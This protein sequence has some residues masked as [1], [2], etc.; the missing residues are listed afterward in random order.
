MNDIRFIPLVLNSNQMGTQSLPQMDL[1]LS[2]NKEVVANL[3]NSTHGNGEAERFGSSALARIC[4]CLTTLVN[5]KI[6]HLNCPN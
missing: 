2:L 5:C 6:T 3:S 4:F 1:K